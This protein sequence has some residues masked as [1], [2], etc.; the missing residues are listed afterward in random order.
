MTDEEIDTS[1]I[2]P[3]DDSF[4]ANAKWRLP[5]LYVDRLD[6]YQAQ[7]CAAYIIDQGLHEKRKTER[8][9]KSQ[10]LVHT[11]FNTSLIVSYSRPFTNHKDLKGK[12]EK[13]DKGTNKA[14]LNDHVTEVLK[15]TETI[16]L[17]HRVLHLRDTAYAH[18]DA[19]SHLFEG[20]DYT[21]LVPFMKVVVNL[22]QL[23]TTRLKVMIGKWIKYLNE[24]I[25]PLKRR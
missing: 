10:Q 12:S 14:P 25:P 20:L 16:K 2:P 3:L 7:E 21:K 9:R 15:E 22:N 5:R 11:A 17:H 24:Q 13:N 19:R 6:F 1:D 4:F 23:E 18:S 8:A